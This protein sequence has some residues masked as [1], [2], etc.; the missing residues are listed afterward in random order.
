MDIFRQNGAKAIWLNEE[1][2]VNSYASF[3]AEF[4]YDGCDA[5]QFSI[6]TDTKYELY[7]NGHLAG[8]GQYED[9]PREKVYDIHTISDYVT[10][11]KNLVSVLAYSQ[12]E[13]SFQ[14][15]SGLPMV[16]F[17][18]ISGEKVLLVSDGQV[19]CRKALDFINGEFERI[20]AQR[21]Y[22]FGFDLRRDDGWREKNVSADWEN[23]TVVDDSAV[24]YSPRPISLLKLSDVCCGKVMSQ[25]QFTVTD[26]STVSQK[27]QYAGLAFCEAEDVLELT[28]DGMKL[29]KEDVYWFTDLGEEMAG[30]IALDI[31][32]EDGA[33]LDIAF[34]EHL[35]DLRVRSFVGDRNFAFRCVC[36]EGRQ[37]LR[38]Y[39]RRMAGRYLQ[40][41]AH[42][43]IRTVYQAGIHKVEYP[44]EFVGAFRSSDRLFNR[45]YTVSAK[46]LH[47]CMHDHYEDCPQREQA[48][49]GMDSR[50]QMVTGYYAFGETLMPKTSLALLGMGQR[51][52]GMLEIT[53]PCIFEERT[54]PSFALAWVVALREYA[55]FSGDLDFIRQMQGK[56]RKALDFFAGHVENDI[57][58]RPH[59]PGTWNFYEWT[60][61]MENWDDDPA[62]QADAPLTC[63]YLLA[64]DS[65]KDLCLWIGDEA[66]GA[67]ANDLH[68]RLSTTFH[69]TFYSEEKGVYQS[70]L[71]D[72]LAPQFSQLTQ[73]LALVA[74]CVPESY[75]K[76]IRAR[77]LDKELVE[78]SLSF[79]MFQYD[80]LMQEPETYGAYVLDDI[81]RQWGYMLYNG[82][83]SFWETILGEADFGGAG[84]LCH[85][86]SAVPIYIFW[87]YVLGIYPQ[88]P[89]YGTITPS[90]CCGEDMIISA[91]LKTPGGIY[92]VT[93]KA[94]QVTVEK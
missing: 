26:G 88:A 20:N 19:K 55:L 73:A 74:G 86:W 50:N 10:K 8:F 23:A 92:Q 91:E 51:D 47:L 29:K 39:I 57:L 1:R 6:A 43:G 52:S 9:F 30:Y 53:A 4:E 87:R 7:I 79:L 72:G 66:D 2:S 28:D 82:A 41:F 17:A 24:T 40:F 67:W 70:Y 18:A 85:G 75:Q 94:G 48:L 78:V 22:N 80:A 60:E 38:F 46:T 76:S 35:A 77:L 68:E 37:T 90:P 14:H 65:Y 42:K 62:I 71:S 89:G 36:R 44:L 61:G 21:S 13:H 32:A 54:I 93:K 58:L 27:M 63:F 31:E 11:G 69:R 12:G 15:I 45:I 34:G 56:I 16:I 33:I 49:Y 3:Q 84:S 59:E 83:T 25:G 64:L 81:E 5:V